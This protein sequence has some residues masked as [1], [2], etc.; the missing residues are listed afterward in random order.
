MSEQA[1]IGDLLER[2]RIKRVIVESP[3]KGNDYSDE[4]TNRFYAKLCMAYCLFINEAPFASHI[5]YTQEGILDDKNS[6]EWDLGIRAGFSW[7]AMADRM[8][9][10]TDLGIT[11]GMKLGIQNAFEIGLEIQYRTLGGMTLSDV[12]DIKND[13]KAWR[14][15]RDW[16][17]RRSTEVL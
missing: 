15:F 12:L 9:V 7:H 4:E 10:F 14:N 6:K 5:L 13:P 1:S 3:F 2:H 8:A 16:L 17:S 11:P